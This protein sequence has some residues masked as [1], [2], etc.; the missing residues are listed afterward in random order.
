MTPRPIAAG[1]TLVILCLVA[2]ALV[3]WPTF[4]HLLAIGVSG[5]EY[6]H[7]I[8]VIPIFL[9]AVWGLRFE[10]A[11]LP[12][13][14]FWP[15]L[16]ALAA[17]GVVWLTGELTFIRLLTEISVIAM[18]PLVVLTVV[19]YRWLWAL[20]FPLFFL[21]FAVPVRGPLVNLQVDLTAR[22]AHWGLLATGIPVHRDGPYFELPTGKWSI[23]EAC[24][25]IEYLSACMML[26]VLYAW[27]IFT[28]NR[29]RFVFIVGAI[30]VGMCGNW[31]RAYLTIWIAH[32]SDNRFLRNDH[33]T[34]GWILF[35]ALLFMYCSIGWYFRDRQRTST[36]AS[37]S[38][39]NEVLPKTSTSR[40]HL[41]AVSAIALAT[42]VAWPAINFSIGRAKLYG[43][44]EIAEVSPAVGWVKVNDSTVD[45][46][47][48]LINP[49]RA[50]VQSFE[51][52][53]R[54]V[55]VFIGIFANQSWTSKLVTSVNQFV[56]SET[57]RWNLVS[58]GVTHTA[59]LET[60]LQVKTGV[61]LGAGARIMAW[62]WYWVHGANTSG[63][64][65]AKLYQLRARLH[66]Q[67]DISAWI[68]IYTNVEPSPEVATGTLIE[69][70]KDMGLS[71]ERALV[72]TTR[73]PPSQ[74]NSNR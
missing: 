50:S 25:G 18:V 69:F 16:I 74:L 1:P 24:S 53:G 27:I 23:A 19:G 59:Y 73:R 45:W 32:I 47:P 26:S 67:D 11:N 41:L 38:K 58:R 43:P 12:T 68:A 51:N 7:R 46:K 22:F 64:I 49:T 42:L 66:G 14:P 57:G 72:E 33:G 40:F 60:P 52:N 34:F 2:V 30:V 48:T 13:R 39:R 31:M 56:T 6:T 35:A 21:L 4:N 9:V 36:P 20:G 55:D 65:H 37:T 71:L 61:I 3:Y 28:S 62:Q 17:A 63:D 54:R 8:F 15:G 29:K 5:E 10:I 44:V 70:M